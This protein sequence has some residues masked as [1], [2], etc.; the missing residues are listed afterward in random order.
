MLVGIVSN[1]NQ[2]SDNELSDEEENVSSEEEGENDT[3]FYHEKFLNDS[4]NDIVDLEENSKFYFL[5]NLDIFLLIFM[6][7]LRSF[8]E[9]LLSNNVTVENLFLKTKVGCLFFNHN[10]FSTRHR[11][12]NP[13]HHLYGFQ[14]NR[15]FSLKI[16]ALRV[17]E[18]DCISHS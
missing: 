13:I 3:R 9:H 14:I 12:Q 10:N 7:R 6:A 5:W 11:D 15:F 4:K 1:I 8:T 16:S 2:K 18:K 17:V